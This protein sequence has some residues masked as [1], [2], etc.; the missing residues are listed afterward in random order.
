MYELPQ[1]LLVADPINRYPIHSP[2]LSQLVKG[3]DGGPKLYI[4]NESPERT[5]NPIGYLVRLMLSCGSTG[6]PEALDGM[7]K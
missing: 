7:W 5:R 2:M 1:S 6:R 3:A 4:Q